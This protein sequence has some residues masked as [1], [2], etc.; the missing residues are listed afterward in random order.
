MRD[1]GE[2]VPAVDQ[3]RDF[4]VA[5]HIL[6]TPSEQDR[7]IAGSRAPGARVTKDYDYVYPQTS[8]DGRYIAI[9]VHHGTTPE[10][11]VFISEHD[12]KSKLPPRWRPVYGE[13]DHA[14]AI[15]LG[16]KRL[17]AIRRQDSQ[18]I[19]EEVQLQDL[20]KRRVLHT[21]AAPLESLFEVGASVYAVEAG[22]TGRCLLRLHS[23]DVSRVTGRDVSVA[24]AFGVDWLGRS[25]AVQLQSW[26]SPGSWSSLDEAGVLRPL[27]SDAGP[28]L[29]NPFEVWE[30]D[31][32]ARDGEQI[33]LVLIGPRGDRKPRY[34]WLR[35][36]G[37]YGRTIGPAFDPARRAFLDMGGTYVAAQIRGGGERG[38][39]W[40][41]A[42]R[43]AK[44]IKTVEDVIDVARFL[45]SRGFGE[46][47]GIFA[48]GASAGGIPIGGLLVRE[49]S[50]VDG[51]AILSGVVNVL[52]WESTS[53]TG[54]A[55]RIEFGSA[56]TPE[57]ARLLREIDVFENAKGGVPY[58]PVL[59][60]T[61][62]D[63][64]RVPYWQSTKLAARLQERTAGDAPILLRVSAG[65]HVNGRSDDEESR[66][67]AEL[68]SFALASVHYAGN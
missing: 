54:P 39:A 51:V 68:V 30:L 31:A 14:I 9:D 45:R 2:K 49:P 41:E 66:L 3:A 10:G 50:L 57:G 27:A 61:A 44:K 40:H 5:E 22:P 19:V 12:P 18:S 58:P 52:K 63:D 43:G 56:E 33:H 28:T 26:S 13:G 20:T 16:Y 38:A 34:V 7:E 32:P 42:G 29:D 24:T 67:D 23:A 47:G 62:T 35:A 55:Q 15:S 36:Y 60:V 21:S 37:S 59:L 25:A 17:L 1:R 53:A 11:E 6:G 48:F 64:Y 46:G 65:G 4:N 8:L